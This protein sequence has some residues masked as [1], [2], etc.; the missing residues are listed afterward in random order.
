MAKEAIWRLKA[1]DMG[2]YVQCSSCGRRVSAKHFIFA[3]VR[4]DTCP[5]CGAEMNLDE[6]DE[7]ILSQ[8]SE[9]ALH[10]Y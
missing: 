6:M 2:A 7:D 5:T 1:S 8:I 9:E 4:T 3:D 10:D